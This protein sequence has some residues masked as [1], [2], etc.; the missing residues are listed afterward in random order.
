MWSSRK[1][2]RKKVTMLRDGYRALPGEVRSSQNNDGKRY[3]EGYFSVTGVP[4]EITDRA[5]TYIECFERGAFAE[6]IRVDRDNIKV[7]LEHG[8]D[9]WVA[10]KPIGKIVELEEDERGGRF[11]V[12]LYDT[13]YVRDLVPALEAKDYSSSFRFSVRDEDDDW[14]Y[15]PG[16]SAHNP[17]GL[18]V[19]TIRRVRVREFG[20]TLWPASPD[21]SA[22]L[23]SMNEKFGAPSER[24]LRKEDEK[25]EVTTTDN[26][27][28]SIGTGSSAG[29]VSDAREDEK[30][31]NDKK[32]TP[33][34]KTVEE[35]SAR[36]SEIADELESFNDKYGEA[37]FT[38]EDR[39]VFEELRSEAEQLERANAEV[40]ERRAL[41]TRLANAGKTESPKDSP[42]FHKNSITYDVEELRKESYSGD[43]YRRR[44]ADNAERIIE[45]TEYSGSDDEARAKAAV[46]EIVREGDPD[47]RLATRIAHTSSEEYRR[48]FAKWVAKQ[49]QTPDEQ[50]A[51][52]LGVD[53]EGGYGVPHNLDPTIILTSDGAINPLRRLARVERITGKTLQLVTSSGVTVT[54]DTPFP[55]EGRPTTDGSPKLAQPEF[56]AGRVSAYLEQTIEI[57]AGYS[58]LDSQ[59]TRALME[60]KEEEEAA[61]FVASTGDGLTGV[62]G[63][64]QLSTATA[65]MLATG[66]H[67][68]L[69]YA[70]LFALDNALAPRHRGRAKW[71]ANNTTYNTIRLIDENV[72]GDLW[73]G[74]TGGRPASING[75]EAHEMSDMISQG[76]HATHPFVIYGDWSKYLIVDRIG[77]VIDRVPV[78]VDPTSGT[79]TGKRG[80]A[81][82]WWNGAGYIDKNAFRGLRDAASE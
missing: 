36:L 56:N 53:A 67:G 38:S 43:D 61:T 79:P 81:A 46:A 22:S 44:M 59:L 51:M 27:K 74:R 17:K 18:P 29:D 39:T 4:Y 60:A 48:A 28:D 2:H 41:V 14:D 82:F 34:Y 68:T 23:R 62:E 1:S 45:R 21:A 15:N 40:E 55:G 49:Y 9:P 6:S 72:G 5:G 65:S 7:L 32:E 76:D 8:K 77:M 12:E 3:L 66:A 19:R 13:S 58:G 33:M 20:P 69:T 63:I 30:E 47:G 80:L 11:K 24:P 57:E 73:T 71:L 37:E 70:D 42:A 16:K 35:R 64:N 50:R 52:S 25:E 75:H 78:V 54:R 26:E 10:D 31:T